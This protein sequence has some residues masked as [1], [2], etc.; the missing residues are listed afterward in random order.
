M[1]TTRC[2][3]A[4]ISSNI[5]QEKRTGMNRITQ[6]ASFLSKNL[7]LTF[8]SSSSRVPWKSTQIILA[9]D[10]TASK[11]HIPRP[12]NF[13]KPVLSC[14]PFHNWRYFTSSL[15]LFPYTLSLCY[16]NSLLGYRCPTTKELWAPGS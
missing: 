12:A 1:K 10:Y 13:P 11:A 9:L 4:L 8:L 2:R 14:T 7:P 3:G 6:Q 5:L 16:L 15:L